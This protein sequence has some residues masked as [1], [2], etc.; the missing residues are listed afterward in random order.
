MRILE[1]RLA[2]LE[3]KK[4]APTGGLVVVALWESV[5]EAIARVKPTGPIVLVPAKDET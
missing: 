2:R 4:V 3:E 1:S 5:E